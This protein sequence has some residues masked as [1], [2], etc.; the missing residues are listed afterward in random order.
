[1]FCGA[2]VFK[3]FYALIGVIAFLP[4]FVVQVVAVNPA[5]ATLSIHYVYPWIA[6]IGISALCCSEI[7]DRRAEGRAKS[8]YMAGWIGCIIAGTFVGN[9]ASVHFARTFAPSSHALNPT[10]TLHFMDALRASMADLKILRVDTAIISLAPELFSVGSWLRPQDWDGEPADPYVDTVIFFENSFEREKVAAQ[11]QVMPKAIAYEVPGTNVRLL[12]A[13]PIKK[14]SRISALAVPS[15]FAFHGFHEREP[16]MTWSKITDPYLEI[17]SCDQRAITLDVVGY[18][19]WPPGRPAEKTIDV[20]VE[21]NGQLLTVLNFLPS[22]QTH[23]L[24]LPISCLDGIMRVGFSFELLI[25][26][27]EVSGSTDTRALGVG[28]RGEPKMQR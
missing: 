27:S 12:S 3:S 9:A 22:K 23:S 19:I 1:M 26:P 18:P 10:P 7:V 13:A 4:W 24:V 20:S 17:Y 21:V 25:R 2:I 16:V 6:S 15:A 5:P 11:R 8:Y 14:T 28:V